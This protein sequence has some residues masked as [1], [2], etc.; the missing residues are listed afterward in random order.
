[1]DERV[2]KLEEK[3][4][5]RSTV[6]RLDILVLEFNLQNIWYDEKIIGMLDKSSPTTKCILLCDVILLKDT[7]PTLTTHLIRDS[8]LDPSQKDVTVGLIG[9]G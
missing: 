4:P 9:A 5:G 3:Q 7:L 6:Q 8:K 2:Q 1:M